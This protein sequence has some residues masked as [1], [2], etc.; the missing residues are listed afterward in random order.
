[1]DVTVHIVTFN[2]NVLM[3]F[4]IDHYRKKFPNC[5][6]IIYDNDS[7][8]ETVNICKANSCEMRQYSTNGKIDEQY[9]VNTK[10][11]CWK[12]AK[13]DWIIVCDVDE[14][15]D[16]NSQQ[17]DQ[18]NAKGVT[19][20]RSES[21]QMVNMEDNFDVPNIK[22]GYRNSQDDQCWLYDKCLCFNKKF[23]DIN[24]RFPG[25]HFADSIGQIVDSRVYKMYHYRYVNCDAFIEKMSRD[26]NR[27]SEND[28]KTN[29][30]LHCTL[31]DDFMRERF[32]KARR[33]AIKILP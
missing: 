4:S 10:N 24:Y 30:G 5:H 26:A 32:M 29:C 23:I 33:N 21:W 1:M 8:D 16:I 19:R 25:C 11:N 6:I 3:Q 14:L 28:I 13:T 15:L 22:F 18:E 2:E 17:L 7:V 27:R 12:N 20:I 9:L 31:G